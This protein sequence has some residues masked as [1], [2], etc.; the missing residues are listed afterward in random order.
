LGMIMEEMTKADW[1]VVQAGD[2]YAY[3]TLPDGRHE[4]ILPTDSRF[5]AIA[6]EVRD[7]RANLC[8]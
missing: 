8:P 4:V 3:R 6:E 1:D 5:A 7:R 2:K